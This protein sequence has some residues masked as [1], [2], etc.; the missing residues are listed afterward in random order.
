MK[1][2]I[3]ILSVVFCILVTSNALGTQDCD[4]VKI[5]KYSDGKIINSKTEY[6]C[7]SPPTIIVQYLEDKKKEQKSKAEKWAEYFKP[8]KPV[9]SPDP[10]YYGNYAKSEPTKFDMFLYGLFK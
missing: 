3:V 2:C 10:T 1:T 5:V 7:D 4:Y 9:S 8:I 6:V